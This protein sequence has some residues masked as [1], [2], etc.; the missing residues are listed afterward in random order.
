M[1]KYKL[2][3]LEAKKMP[4]QI[5]PFP[6]VPSLPYKYNS[7]KDIPRICVVNLPCYY[8]MM[9]DTKT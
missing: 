3:H 4:S 7:Y 8:N 5:S 2:E 6:L 1:Q 9:V